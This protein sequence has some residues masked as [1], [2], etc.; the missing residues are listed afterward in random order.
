MDI[1][2]IDELINSLK[3][4][5]N[6]NEIINIPDFGKRDKIEL[7]GN[8]YSFIV[9][10]NRSGHRKPKCTFQLREVHYKDTPLLR[11]DLIGRTHK[12]PPGD[13]PYSDQ[14]IP[15]PHLHILDPDY[16][17]SIAYPLD[18]YYAKMKLSEEVL[19]DLAAV[20]QEFLTRCNVGNINDY[21]INYQHILL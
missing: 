2:L 6:S 9:D 19:N 13:F 3:M 17:T 21:K 7:K 5:V 8:N 12:N 16:G 1:S 20:L 10:L 4:I 11:L 18:S 14:D 15:C